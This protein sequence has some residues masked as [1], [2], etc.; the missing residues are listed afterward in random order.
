MSRCLEES[1]RGHE[2][3]ECLMRPLEVVVADEVLEPLL[4]VHDMREHRAAQELVPQRL[5]EPLHL[6]KRLR[7]LRSTAD[8]LNAH[9]L[10]RFLELGPSSPHRVLTP[11]VSQHLARLAKRSDT[12]LERLHH[13]RRLLMVC[14]RVPNDEAT[15]VVHEHARIQTLGATKSKREDV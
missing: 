11:V 6:A 3:V 8:V 5:P 9:P 12:T 4:R 7:M 2:T 14:E 15:V 13:E 1:V 10:E